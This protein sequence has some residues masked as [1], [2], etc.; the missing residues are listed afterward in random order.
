MTSFERAEVVSPYWSADSQ[1]IGFV[2]NPEG[3][4]LAYTIDVAGGQP[5]KFDAPGANLYGWNWSHDGRWIFFPSNRSGSRQLWKIPAGGGVAEQMTSEG[6]GGC[7]PSESPDGEVAYY[8]RPG[9]VWSVPVEGGTEREVVAF[10]L[11]PGCIE[12][13]RL[14][15]YFVANSTVTKGGDLMFYRFPNGPIKKVT[16]VETRYGHSVS[17]D[18][19]YLLFTKMTSTGSDLMAVENFR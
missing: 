15:L 7:P 2:A 1:Q 14:G 12:V 17:P 18:G 10:D 9:G 13:S 6:A 11:D 16:G 4:Y 5:R 19:R 3:A 8:A